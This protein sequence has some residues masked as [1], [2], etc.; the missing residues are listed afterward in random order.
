M[1]FPLVLVA[2]PAVLGLF[3]AKK[4]HD[5]YSDNKKAKNL[6]Q[7]AQKTFDRGQSRLRS[8][9]KQCTWELEALGRKKFDLWDRQ[10]GR[11]VSLFEQLRNVELQ[12]ASRADQLGAAG[13]SRAELAKMKQLSGFASEVVSG[14]ATALGTGALVGM[15]SYG[16]AMMFATASTGTA[17]GSLTG[18]AATNATLAW[19]GGGSLAA[20]GLGMAGGMAVLGGIVAGPVLAVG[21]LVL[22]SKAKKNLASA[23]SNLAKAKKAS[24]EMRAAAALLDGIRKVGE[25]FNELLEG[26][27]ERTTAALDALEAVIAR[28][29]TDYARYSIADRKTVHL[30]VMF[31]QGLKVV[32]ETPLLT[33]SGALSQ[34]YPKALRHGRQLLETTAS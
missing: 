26:L 4:G 20:G 23:R 9:R 7:E 29:G 28:A 22:A 34:G 13:F 11:F 16:G 25:L 2:V 18:A 10:M 30:A 14:G 8:A 32:L 24:K 17:I 12:G 27:D 6:N 31:A 19:F 5:A 33:E 1:P 15:A 21:G 3:G